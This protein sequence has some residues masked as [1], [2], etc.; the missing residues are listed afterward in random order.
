MLSKFRT[1]ETNT[2]HLLI[3]ICL[4][5]QSDGDLAFDDDE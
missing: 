2:A 4:N 1:E 3:S 5:D